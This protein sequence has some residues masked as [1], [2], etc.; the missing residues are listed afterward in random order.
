MNLAQLVKPGLMQE[1]LDAYQHF[2]DIRLLPDLKK[3]I[4]HQ[5]RIQEGIKE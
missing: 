1:Q 2:V 5:E 4:V 3:T